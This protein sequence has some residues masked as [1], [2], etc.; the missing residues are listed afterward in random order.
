MPFPKY[1]RELCRLNLQSLFL[2]SSLSVCV[3]LG[4]V[5]SYSP[6]PFTRIQLCLGLL[7]LIWGGKGRGGRGL[8]NRSI[9]WHTQSGAT[10]KS[11]RPTFL[12]ICSRRDRELE[13][14]SCSRGLK[15]M[16]S[17]GNESAQPQVWRAGGLQGKPVFLCPIQ[18][19]F[20]HSLGKW[21]PSS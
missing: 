5:L 9:L 21:T 10:L 13:L 16:L 1:V 15:T 18:S 12:N 11:L 17:E 7:I 8:E 19:S 20:A 6:L 2:G 4:M 14:I 3:C